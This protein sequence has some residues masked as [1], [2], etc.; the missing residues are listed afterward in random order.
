MSWEDPFLLLF[1]QLPCPQDG[2]AGVGGHRE[3]HVAVPAGVAADPVVVQ[4]ALLLRALEALLDRR[5]SG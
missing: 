1:I 5:R 3:G 2:L 4:A